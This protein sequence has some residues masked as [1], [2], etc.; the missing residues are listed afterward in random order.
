[1]NCGIVINVSD[2]EFQQSL[3]GLG[4]FTIP[5]C[6]KGDK[7]SFLVVRPPTETIDEGFNKSHGK[8]WDGYDVAKDVCGM[9]SDRDGRYERFGVLLC[10][11]APTFPAEIEDLERKDAEV[12]R[13]RIERLKSGNKRPVESEDDANKRSMKAHEIWIKFVE[14]CRK[15]I[16]PEEIAKAKQNHVA[17]CQRLVLQGDGFWARPADQKNI[18]DPHLRA[19]RF[20]GQSR[21]WCYTPV[22]MEPCSGCGKQQPIGIVRCGDCGAILDEGRA[23]VM[24]PELYLAQK[25]SELVE[26]SLKK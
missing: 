10:A 8:T 20:L 26:Q 6:K 18:T 12:Y 16:K 25:Q 19:C 23:R 21:P 1:M 3:G 22:Q 15:L 17:E 2:Q 4:I 24:Y 5:A 14:E 13:Q 11:A 9:N 7:Y